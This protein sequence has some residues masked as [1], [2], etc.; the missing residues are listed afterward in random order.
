MGRVSGATQFMR[1]TFETGQTGTEASPSS[2]PGF[3]TLS[4][5]L[6]GQLFI[7]ITKYLSNS[8][9]KDYFDL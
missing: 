7:I 3:L 9:K 6:V 5:A 4:R 2:A 8:E 1:S